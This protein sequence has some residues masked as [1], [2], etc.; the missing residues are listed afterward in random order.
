MICMQTGWIGKILLEVTLAVL[1]SQ[2]KVVLFNERVYR[3]GKIYSQKF[4]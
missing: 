2:S 3:E 1:F 4:R